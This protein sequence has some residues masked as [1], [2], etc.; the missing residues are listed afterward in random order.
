MQF[1]RQKWVD[2]GLLT[3]EQYATGVRGA[4]ICLWGEGSDDTRTDSQIWPRAA[5]MAEALWTDPFS[6][7]ATGTG[8]TAQA[9]A[10]GDV[11]LQD[12]FTRLN[13]LRSRL[14]REMR[15]GA[16][17]LYP[18]ACNQIGVMNC[19]HTFAPEHGP[20]TATAPSA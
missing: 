1:T 15:V 6:T 12:M 2:G 10:H 19:E 11:L 5:G 14:V 7:V 13:V 9:Q 18:Q 17:P 4:E 8:T 3:A 20:A 16:V